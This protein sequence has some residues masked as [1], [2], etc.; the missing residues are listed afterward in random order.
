MRHTF[1]KQLRGKYLVTE[2][3]NLAVPT[4]N[5]ILFWIFVR[6]NLDVKRETLKE[7]YQPYLLCDLV[8]LIS[9]RKVTDSKLRRNLFRTTRTFTPFWLLKSVLKQ[10]T[11]TFTWRINYLNVRQ[12][13]T[14]FNFFR[15]GKNFKSTFTFT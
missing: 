11:A 3:F 6:I 5:R 15:A 9:F 14:L 12:I 13:I 10:W 7:R 8:F 2:H 1:H 4:V